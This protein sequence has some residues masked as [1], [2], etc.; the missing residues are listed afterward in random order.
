MYRTVRL[1][2]I[3]V[4]LGVGAVALL[5]WYAKPPADDKFIQRF[6][7]NK[8][9][10]QRLRHLLA[11]D[12]SIRDVMDSGVQM[13]DSPIF[14]VPPTAQISSPRFKE[15]LDLL[16]ATGGIRVGRS[17]GSNPDICIGV[18]ADGWAGDTRHKWIC[19]IGDPF[20]SQGHFSRK[21]IEDH[22]YLA[23]DYKDQV[24]GS[25]QSSLAAM[26]RDES[27]F[28]ACRRHRLH[29]AQP[30]TWRHTN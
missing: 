5:S 2:L 12:P 24:F 23:Q 18:W 17:E 15:Y 4:G 10:Y 27:V 3:V 7:K 22:W 26:G 11:G 16:H 25:G 9:D 13:S 14:V 20:L 8:G 19:W 29:P 6:I 21:L 1:A 28:G 30:P